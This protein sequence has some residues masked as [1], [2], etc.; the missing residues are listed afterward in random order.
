MMASSSG[1]LNAWHLRLPSID[2]STPDGIRVFINVWN[3]LMA[4]LLGLSLASLV[5]D[6]K[7]IR[8]LAAGGGRRHHTRSRG[9]AGLQEGLP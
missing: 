3:N 5:D 6:L 2:L 7:K 9:G 4:E 1:A 8:S